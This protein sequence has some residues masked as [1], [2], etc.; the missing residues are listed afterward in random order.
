MT[1]RNHVLVT[2]GTGK[3]GRRIVEG[4]KAHGVTVRVGSR[5]TEPRFDWTDRATWQAALADIDSV[6][7]AFQPDLAVPGAVETIRAFTELAVS[8]G[9]SRLVLLSGRGEEEAQHCEQIVQDSGVT[10][11]ILRAS[12]FFQNFSES[13]LIGS[14][15]SGAVYLPA[16]DVKE[17]FID[18]EDIADVA[19]AAL[20]ED[21]H[22]GQL[23]ELTSPRLLT[24]AETV[25]EIAVAI[26]RPIPYTQISP[27]DY[28][29]AMEAEQTPAYMVWLVNYLF[30]TVLDGRNACVTDGVERALGRKPRDFSEYVRDTAATG[31][32]NG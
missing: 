7:I 21:R 13:F 15:L 25:S 16:G 11:T 14:I 10:W 23:Y 28:V 12:W 9:V 2:G 32:W 24:F 19:I 8:C 1:S 3:T 22:A 17:P 26:G 4:L 29:A 20:T 30:T 6:Y 5:S 18:A 31:V 27:E